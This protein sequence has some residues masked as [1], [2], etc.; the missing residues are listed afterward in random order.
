MTCLAA[1]LATLSV[2]LGDGMVNVD[3]PAMSP[4]SHVSDIVL[5]LD[6]NGSPHVAVLST[7]LLEPSLSYG[8]I[9]DGRWRT[10][11]VPLTMEGV[12]PIAQVAVLPEDASNTGAVE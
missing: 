9:V 11:Q 5:E 3:L 2:T 1:G 8:R 6:D 4:G 10:T 12:S 7:A